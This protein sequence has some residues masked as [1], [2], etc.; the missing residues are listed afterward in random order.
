M[1]DRH[2]TLNPIRSMTPEAIAGNAFLEFQE[3]K[4]ARK[5][6]AAKYPSW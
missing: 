5:E 1:T 4:S 3:T 6:A 2:P